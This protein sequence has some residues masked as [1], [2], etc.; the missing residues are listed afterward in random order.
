MDIE[1]YKV[2]KDELENQQKANPSFRHSL[3]GLAEPD[4]TLC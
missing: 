4:H 2:N 3:S 1:I